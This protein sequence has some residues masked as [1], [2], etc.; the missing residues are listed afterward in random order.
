MAPIVGGTMSSTNAIQCSLHEES[1]LGYLAWHHD[2]AGRMARGE[3][4]IK[5]PECGRYI[6]A[7]LFYDSASQQ[8]ETLVSSEG[9]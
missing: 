6:W 7:D 4:Q 3:F 8:K 9:G 2:A 5:C 1:K